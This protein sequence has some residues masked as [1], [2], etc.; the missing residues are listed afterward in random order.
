MVEDNRSLEALGRIESDVKHLTIASTEHGKKLDQLDAK[1]HGIELKDEKAHG[2]IKAAVVQDKAAL[3]IHEEHD[4]RRFKEVHR[5]L[6]DACI[7]PAPE[8]PSRARQVVKITGTAGAGGALTLLIL[9]L[10]KLL[11]GLQ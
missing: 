3:A 2:E 11:R 1:L 5:H 10:V 6:R 9:E 7:L 4:D 8:G